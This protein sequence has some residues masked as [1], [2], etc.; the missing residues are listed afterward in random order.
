MALIPVVIALVGTAGVYLLVTSL[1]LGH[2][3][4][5]WLSSGSTRRR[6]LDEALAA[7]MTSAGLEGFSPAQGGAAVIVIFTVATAVTFLVFSAAL[8]AVAVGLFA[9][10]FPIS[11]ARSRRRVRRR[12]A[13]EAWP[14]LLEEV[15]LQAGSLGRS[16]PQ[17]LFD[18]G[19]RCPELAEAFASAQR[20]WLLSTDFGSSLAV[21]KTGLADPSADAACETLLVAHQ[22][23]GSDLPRRLSALVEDRLADLEGRKD[24]ESRQAGVAFARRF[25]LF[26]PLGM[27]LTGLS[28]GNGRAAYQASGGQAV[29]LIGVGLVVACWAW[30]GRIMRLPCE[31]RVFGD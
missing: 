8:P 17:A 3:D 10:T 28:I 4:L 7:W 18:V 6:K 22:V 15:A 20:Q 31:Q 9:G 13:A 1:L 11:A 19:V 14:R 26:V 29:A 2:R 16:I 21:L 12:R 27:A 24:L 23:G 30:S 5:G 25:V